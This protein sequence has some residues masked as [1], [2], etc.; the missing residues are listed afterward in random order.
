MPLMTGAEIMHACP[1]D[2]NV[3]ICPLITFIP[4]Y[5]KNIFLLHIVLYIV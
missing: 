4:L 5:K 3:H 1:Q 2:G